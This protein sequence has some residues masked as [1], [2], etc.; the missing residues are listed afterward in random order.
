MNKQ[1]IEKQIAEHEAKIA[2]LK[3]ELKSLQPLYYPKSVMGNGFVPEVASTQDTFIQ[4]YKN[5]GWAFET[6][7]ACE[8]HIKAMQALAKLRS[9]PGRCKHSFHSWGIF[10]EKTELTKEDRSIGMLSFKA[11]YGFSS[12]GGVWF[13]SKSDAEYAME[14]LGYD[15]LKAIY[16]NYLREDEFQ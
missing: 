16:D 4:S 2:E 5:M 3:D 14:Q 1:D 13:K 15:A 9:M 12:L 8:R 7:E 10:A 11:D 6:E